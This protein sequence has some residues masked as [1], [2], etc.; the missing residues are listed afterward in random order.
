MARAKIH[1]IRISL[2]FLGLCDDDDRDGRGGVLRE[3]AGLRVRTPR[4][5]SGR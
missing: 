4:P 1:W 3:R 2:A 5:S